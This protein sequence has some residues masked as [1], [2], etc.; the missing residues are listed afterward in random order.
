M[1]EKYKYKAEFHAHTN[2]ASACSQIS[3]EELVGRYC[4]SGYTTVVLTNHFICDTSADPDEKITNFLAD[5]HKTS[6]LGKNAGLNIVLGAE[7]RFSE[8]INDYL[9]YGISEDDMYTINSLL[10]SG[11]DNFYKKFKN[12]R[13]VIL[14]A[15]PFRDGMELANP[16][17]VDGVEVFN[18]HPGHNSRIA[19]AA[20]YAREHNMLISAGT[21]F[22]HF[23]HEGMCSIM[24]QQPIKTSYD[25]ADVLKKRD[26]IVDISGFKIIV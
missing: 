26:F 11:I 23:G 19:F 7:L 9:I 13:N 12:D 6:E 10:D 14:Q 20:K 16:K 18:M 5:Y 25:A 24:T 3:P 17:S 2:P 15:H 22:H 4:K 8:N 21:D 1:T